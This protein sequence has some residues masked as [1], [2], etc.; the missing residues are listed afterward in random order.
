MLLSLMIL[1]L[2]SPFSFVCSCCTTVAH[3]ASSRQ[4]I[5]HWKNCTRHDCPVCLPLKNAGDKRNPQCECLYPTKIMRFIKLLTFFITELD[6]NQS[7]HKNIKFSFIFFFRPQLFS[8]RPL[9]DWEALSAPYPA[10]SQ[11][12]P[13]ST[14]PARSTPAL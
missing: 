4:I 5:S 2:F 7:H 11:A 6:L 1:C 3:C 10:P 13:T 12:L 9:Q 8:G 14:P